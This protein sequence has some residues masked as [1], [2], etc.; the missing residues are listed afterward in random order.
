MHQT[1]LAQYLQSLNSVVCNILMR[2]STPIA[3]SGSSVLL[4][5]TV[6]Q[7]KSVVLIWL[8]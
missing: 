3:Q 7:I 1:I 8:L 4:F 2:S 6:W 5:V